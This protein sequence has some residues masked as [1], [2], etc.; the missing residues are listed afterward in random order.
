[1]PIRSLLWIGR[2]RHFAGDLVADAPSLDVTWEGSVD[3]ALAHS[4]DAL[5]AIVLD[6]DD[7][8]SGR[9]DLERLRR[10]KPGHPVLVRTDP[11]ADAA[12][13]DWQVAGATGV[14]YRGDAQHGPTMS[15]TLIDAIEHAL[16]ARS[17]HDRSRRGRPER[18]SPTP[19][20]IGRSAAMRR[21][22]ALVERAGGSNVT[23]LVT[24]ET[25]TGKELIA[26]AIHDVGLRRE[27]PFVAF[28]CAAFPETLLESELFGHTKGAFTGADREKP[29]LFE[30][31][32]GG[33]LF[34]DEVS[35][36]S[37]PFQAKLLRVLQER[38]IRALGSRRPRRID[39]RV[40]AACNRDLVAEVRAGRFREDLF[41]RLAV[42]PITVPPLRDRPDDVLPLAEHFLA[43]HGRRER[44]ARVSLSIEAAHRLATHRWPGNVRE[45]ENEMQRALALADPGDTLG[46]ADFSLR[47]AAPLPSEE[48]AAAPGESLRES[49]HRLE[50]LLL[51]RAL[52]A[53]QGQRS[54]T[55]RSLGIT[56]EGLYK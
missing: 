51:R 27:H 18:E 9:R 40:V 34:L 50:A 55:A 47:V 44:K 42:F 52:A 8:E 6:V 25:G 20:I 24:G 33:T 22:F 10:E 16:S 3:L 21:V 29:G 12:T 17:P 56:R 11:R 38:E 7:E 4:F 43:L 14:L 2:A 45:L 35:E 41:Y 32:N 23:V 39:V 13:T 19:G 53:H 28:N 15:R 46:P 26:R 37:G 31:A 36:T 30:T 1:M 5:D 49:L 54:A 48:I